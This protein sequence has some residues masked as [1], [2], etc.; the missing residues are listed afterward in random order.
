MLVEELGG[1]ALHFWGK[2]SERVQNDLLGLGK[3]DRAFGFK[4]RGIPVIVGERLNAQYFPLDLV[5]AGDERVVFD[6]G[7]D[8]EGDGG[9]A[10]DGDVAKVAGQDA[11]V[12]RA[13]A[14]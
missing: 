1:P 7:I 8:D 10:A 14:L 6:D 3:G 5:V 12:G 2:A 4:E 9:F 11:G 13:G